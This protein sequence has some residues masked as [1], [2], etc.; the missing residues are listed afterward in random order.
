MYKYISNWSKRFADYCDHKL[1]IGN[2]DKIAEIQ[3]GTYHILSALT[4]LVVVYTLAILL[5]IFKEALLSMVVFSLL[6]YF[7]GGVHAK[8]H[9]GCTF[10]GNFIVAFLPLIVAKVLTYINIGIY[11][12]NII[13]GVVYIVC[14]IIVLKYAPSD[15]KNKPIYSKGLRKKLRLGAVSMLLIYFLISISVPIHASNIITISTVLEVVSIMPM[16]YKIFKNEYG[17]GY[18]VR[19]I[20]GEKDV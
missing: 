3:Y 5:G 6:R 1:C 12:Y 4:K 15:L 10:I 19:N 9:K 17:A 20:G 7:S 8:T 14:I 2:K 16:A 18:G 13:H 11:E